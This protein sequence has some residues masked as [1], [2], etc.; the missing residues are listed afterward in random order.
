MAIHLAW[1]LKN[2]REK[3]SETIRIMIIQLYQKPPSVGYCFSLSKLINAYIIEDQNDSSVWFKFSYFFK[4]NLRHLDKLIEYRNG[5]AHGTLNL[6]AENFNEISKAIQSLVLQPLYNSSNL[7]ISNITNIDNINFSIPSDINPSF[8]MLF[9]REGVYSDD[10][11]LKI[12]GNELILF[13]FIIADQSGNIFLWNQKSGKKGVFFNYLENEGNKIE[14]PNLTDFT[15][16]PYDDWKKTATTLF[17]NYLKIRNDFAF[18]GVGRKRRG[19]K[20]HCALAPSSRHRAC[21]GT[22]TKSDGAR[23]WW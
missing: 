15:G 6:T 21:K 2:K 1:I 9:I 23:I 14:I 19:W 4:N 17:L 22:F 16:F 12:F 8:Q 11:D 5:D 20:L 13:P 3:I 7:Y 18:C 10:S